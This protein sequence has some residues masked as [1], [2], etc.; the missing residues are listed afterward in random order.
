MKNEMDGH[1]SRNDSQ[2]GSLKENVN[3]DVGA[4]RAPALSRYSALDSQSRRP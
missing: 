2:A 1:S 4:T 3:S